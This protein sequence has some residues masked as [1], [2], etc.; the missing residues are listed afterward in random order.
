VGGRHKGQDR[1]LDVC[2]QVRPG[3]EDAGQVRVGDRAMQTLCKLGVAS[4]QVV[5]LLARSGGNIRIPKLDVAGSNPVA[6]SNAS[7]SADAS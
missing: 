4:P 2:G 6:R 7:P 5:V 1:G 3:V